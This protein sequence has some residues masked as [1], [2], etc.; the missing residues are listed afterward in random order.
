MRGTVFLKKL[1][2]KNG[3]NWVPGFKE[4][5]PETTTRTSLGDGY[6]R[7]S[8]ASPISRIQNS[9]NLPRVQITLNRHWQAA[10]PTPTV[11]SIIRELENR[12]S[13]LHLFNMPM[14]FIL[15]QWFLL[16]DHMFICNQ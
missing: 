11:T 14:H 9:G 6:S 8:E 5:L 12:L 3:K 15:N 4:I 1:K 10:I 2:N 16:T 13:F 7:V